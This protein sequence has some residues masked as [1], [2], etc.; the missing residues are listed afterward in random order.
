MAAFFIVD[1]VFSIEFPMPEK[2]AI[3]AQSFFYTLFHEQLK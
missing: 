2:P 1:S 3:K